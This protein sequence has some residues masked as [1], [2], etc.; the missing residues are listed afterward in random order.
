VAA[1]LQGLRSS[2]ASRT[3]AERAE[4]VGEKLGM[5]SVERTFPDLQ[6]LVAAR[7]DQVS[8]GRPRACSRRS[9]V[10]AVHRLVTHV[11]GAGRADDDHGV[12]HEPSPDTLSELPST[13]NLL[14]LVALTAKGSRFSSCGKGGNC[15][16]DLRSALLV[17][18]TLAGRSA[19]QRQSGNRRQQPQASVR[20]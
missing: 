10:S 8:S 18:I 4:I 1:E 20:V 12:T 7:P 19:G 2:S 15:D 14:S 9:P 11:P 13:M 5:V 6:P 3:G 17:Q 16:L